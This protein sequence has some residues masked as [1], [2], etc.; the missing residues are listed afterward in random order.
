MSAFVR[1]GKILGPHGIKGQLKLW[2]Y[3]SFL[4]RFQHLDEVFL[5]KGDETR[6]FHFGE[7]TSTHKGALISL[8]E[9]RDRSTAQQ[10]SGCHLCVPEEQRSK[11]P[12]N[13]YYHDDLIGLSVYEPDG[14]RV[15]KVRYI[16]ERGIQDCLCIA[17]ETGCE[18][19]VPFH[20]NFI[21]SVDQEGKKIIIRS[22]PGLL[23]R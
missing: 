3:T 1:L 7:F 16:Y 14:T 4:E 20:R 2:P 9:C 13:Y 22:I 23:D 19:L 18:F 21:V 5:K 12:E 17:D 6:I 8:K 11:L 10:L 15:G